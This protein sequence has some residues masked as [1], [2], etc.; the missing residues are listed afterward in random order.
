MSYKKDLINTIVANGCGTL[1]SI[2]VTFFLPK[3]L[4]IGEYGYFQLFL[5]YS[6][7]VGLLHFGWPDGFYIKN[8]GKYIKDLDNDT[9][10]CELKFFSLSQISLGIAISLIGVIFCNNQD[11]KILFLVIGMSVPL[12]NLRT[13][14]QYVFQATSEIKSYAIVTLSEKII[15]LV[16][17]CVFMLSEKLHFWYYAVAQEIGLAIAISIGVFYL[18]SFYNDTA[19]RPNTFKYISSHICAGIKILIAGLSSQLIVGIVRMFIMHKWNVKTFS[20]ISLTISV[21][22][23]FLIFINSIAIVLFPILRRMD[24]DRLDSVYTKL[25]SGMS[26]VLFAIL[27]FY[28]PIK[29]ILLKWLPQYSGGIRYMAILFP[30][31]IFEC[32][33]A[34]ILMTYMK[35]YDM[36]NEILLTNVA[37]LVM[38]VVWSFFS[39]F[40]FENVT[41]TVLG[42]VIALAFR[43]YLAE[44]FLRKYISVIKLKNEIEEIAMVFLFIASAW[45][46]SILNGLLLYLVIYAVFIFMRRDTVVKLFK[47]IYD[48]RKKFETK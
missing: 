22:N 37:A 17:A 11:Y 15:Y 10:V 44:N 4:S 35:T 25:R 36:E 34:M 43:C 41:V 13:F 7:Y 32:L 12:L 45:Y 27:P 33:T 19:F 6:G 16:V 28:Y 48:R 18:K 3:L 24:I 30:I 8:G 5:L 46:L 2:I 40:I 26:I 47:E 31:C 39:V 1:V 20:E 14:I 21:S 38:S 9:L 42:I 29:I 23:I